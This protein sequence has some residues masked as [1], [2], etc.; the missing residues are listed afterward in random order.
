MCYL[1]LALS[2]HEVRPINCLPNL[3][4]KKFS[5]HKS[6]ARSSYIS[7]NVGSSII[8]GGCRSRSSNYCKIFISLMCHDTNAKYFRS[9]AASIERIPISEPTDCV[10]IQT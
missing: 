7:S 6:N 4:Q 2:S 8:S 1:E 10:R 3:K 5:H 9:D